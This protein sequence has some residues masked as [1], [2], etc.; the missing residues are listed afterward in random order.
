MWMFLCLAIIIV[1]FPFAWQNP[2]GFL[3]AFSTMY[4]IQLNLMFFATFC[5]CF[6]IC[7]YMWTIALTEDVRCDFIAFSDQIKSEPNPMILCKKLIDLI[8]FGSAV[9]RWKNEREIM[10]ILHTCTILPFWL[11]IEDWFF[12]LNRL[13][14]HTDIFQH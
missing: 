7:F 11:T 1:R 9:K 2:A 6:G 4:V 12:C 10:S 14:R 3:I 5:L 8:E 13:C